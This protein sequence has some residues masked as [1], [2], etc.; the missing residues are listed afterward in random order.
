MENR[1][2]VR[3]EDCCLSNLFNFMMFS[4]NDQQNKSHFYFN[5]FKWAN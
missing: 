3:N 4:S 2:E 1:A 5:Y